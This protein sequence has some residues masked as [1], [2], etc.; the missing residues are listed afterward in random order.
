MYQLNPA[1]KAFWQVKS[2]YKALYGGRASSKSHDAA[3][4]AVFLA[5]NYKVRI[6]CARQFQNKIEE[7][8]YT[9]IKDK[10]TNSEFDGEFVITNRSIIHKITGSE[11][12]FY[13]IAR[14]INEIKST[15]NISILWLEEANYLTAEQ[16][17]V[18]APTILRNQGS[19][20]WLIWNPDEYMDFVYQNFVVNPPKDCV[21]RE[22]NYTENPFLTPDM[23]EVIAEEYVRDKKMAEHI[24]GGQ[25]KMGGDKSIISLSYVL[26]AI[27]AHIKLG[28]EPVGKRRT[29]FD[30]ADDGDDLCA[31]IDA[32]GNVI[33]GGD[34]WEGLED[35]LLKSCT[36]VYNHA[37]EFGSS[38]TW[39][40]IGVGATAGAKFA[41]LNASK[42]FSLEYDPFNA[43]GK[44]DD[45]DGTY[46]KLPHVEIKN[47]DHFA[48]LKAQKWEEVADRF[49]KTYEAVELGV[50]YPHD[51]LVSLNSATI[52]AHILKKIKEELPQPRKD[53]DGNGRFMVEQKIKM[54]KRGIKSPN[55]ADAVIMAL[56]TPKRGAAGFFD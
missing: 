29:G 45:P 54:K 42:G 32:H 20:I 6:M 5:A 36:K 8:V 37:V 56:I 1:L 11:F 41:E 31:T 28:W 2:R 46:M 26:A 24:Y 10:I 16:W 48:N 47:K 15:E 44:L 50:K 23:C 43:G 55:V 17:Q 52:P 27:D 33:M 40:S 18:I 51:Q 35:E 21:S 38:I 7:S 4:F 30:V 9:L 13:G 49:R 19:Q 39:D 22:I 14:N 25:P 12:L 3:G 53:L 34:E